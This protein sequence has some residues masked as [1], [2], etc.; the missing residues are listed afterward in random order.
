METAPK[1]GET[2]LVSGLVSPPFTLPVAAV[3]GY[4]RDH[5]AWQVG[6]EVICASGCMMRQNVTKADHPGSHTVW[7][8][9]VGSG[10]ASYDINSPLA[11][12]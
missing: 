2:I 10:W 8:R 12:A 4:D 3:L 1:L 9:R 5:D 6:S 7:I 11:A